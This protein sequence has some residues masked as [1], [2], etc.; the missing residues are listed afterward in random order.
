MALHRAIR[1]LRLDGRTSADL[2]PG[3]FLVER[4]GRELALILARYER[5]LADDGLLD[6][7][8]LLGGAGRA[9]AK[10]PL[11]SLWVLSPL[12]SRLSRLEA[13]LVRS[14]AAGRLV[15]VPGDPVV[16]LD[17]PRQ[18]WPAPGPAD[19]SG[20]GRLTWLFAP[21]Q[22]P[23]EKEARIEIFRALGPA[24]ECREIL[25][26]LYAEKVPFDQVEILTPPGS[27]HA[28]V[29]HLFAERTGLPVTF[30]DGIPVSFTSPGRLFFGL[31][32]WLAGDFSSDELGRLLE[33]GDLALPAGPSGT[34]LPARTACRLLR[35]AMIGW[36]RDRYLERLAA[37]REGQEA[38]LA[39]LATGE[40]EEDGEDTDGRRSGFKE[41]IAGIEAL[42]AAIG[43]ILDIV[44]RPDAAGAYDLRRLCEAFARLIGEYAGTASDLDGRARRALLDRL[45]EFAAESRLPDLPLK[46][47]LGLIRT[48]G[49]SLRVG[50]SPPLAGR[51]HVAALPSG[52]YSGRPYTFVAGLDEARV[53]GRGLQD[54]VLLDEER[55]AISPSLPTS[56]DAL[57]SG[58]YGLAAVLASLRGRI[59]LSYPSF[60]IVEG[61]ESFPS[62]VVLQAFRL[63]RGDPDLDY[64]ALDRALPE[65]AGF[66]PGGPARAFDEAD[67][68]LDRLTTEPRPDGRRSV[69]AN[70][71]AL[72]AGL[73]A[74][75]ARAG[76]RLTA[77]DGLVDIGPLRAEVDPV[78]GDR[79]V[80]SATRLE[81]LAKCPFGYFLRHVLKVQPPE[82][83]AF[84]RSR[85]LDPLQRGSLVHEILCEFMTAVAGRGEE[86]R[87]SRHAAVMTGIAE[88]HVARMKLRVPP[89]SDGIFESERREIRETLDIFM[90]AE[91]KREIKG[92]PLAFEKAIPGESIA[93]DGGR[94]FRLRGF[95]DRVDLDRPG[96]LP[97]HRLQDGQPRAVRGRR[98]FRPGPD[99]PARA[100]RRRP[101]TDAGPGTARPRAA[102][103][104]E[105]L[106][107]PVA[108]GRGRRDHGPG[109]RPGPAPVAARRPSRPPRKG[110]FHRRPR[111]QVRL[112]RLPGRLHLRR[113]RSLGREAR[114]Q[115]R[116]LRGL[117][118]AR[119]VQM[120]AA[121]KK[122]PPDQAARD[123]IRGDL[124]T[125]FLVEAGA[126]SGK[127][128]SL[129][130]RMVALLA[131]GRTS[132]ET[133]AAVT[134][135]RK[136]AAELRG[137][138]QVA[139]EQA[140]LAEKDPR[141]RERLDAALTGLERAFIGTIHSFC[142][143]LLRERPVEAGI[144]PEFR[145]LED[146]EDRILLER[147]WDEYQ[148]HARLENEA[149]LR[150][151]DEAG[152][153]PADLETAFRAIAGFPD[154]EPVAGRPDPPDHE[155][156]RGA[157]EKLV[158]LASKLVPREK[159]E[160]G[161]DG[162]QSLFVRLFRRRRNIGFADGRRLME[163]VELFDKNLAFMPTR[164][165]AKDDGK[166]LLAAAET[167]RDD[168]AR[169]AL[170]VWREFR[171][172]KALAFLRPAVGFYAERRRAEARLN[173]QDQLMLTAR[174]L[175]D[176]PEVRRY[177]RRRFHP[178]LVDE[179]Q[180][181][182]PI[183]A[184]ILFLL[185]GT[186]ETEKDWTR[187][188]PAPGSL[189][190]VG[191]PKQSIYRF[192][193]ADI[194]IYNLVRDRIEASGGETLALSANFRSLG[195]IAD[196]VNP[197]FDPGR[198]GVF[199]AAADA[200]QAGFMPLETVRGRGRGPLSGVRKITVPAVPY[201]R[202][203]DIAG[204]DA[205]RVAGFIAWALA[206]N[207]R[208]DDGAGGDRPAEPGD[209][210]V[211]F[212]YKDRMSRYARRLEERGIPFEIAGS[213]AFAEN[214]EIREVMN[215]LRA[216]DDPDDPVASVAVLRGMFFGLS[217]QDLLD[218]RAA[219]GG[220][221]FL[222]E[223]GGPA[224]SARI[225]S[226]FGALRAWRELATRVPPSVALETDHPGFGPAHPPGHD[227]DGQ[228]PGRQRPQA[229]RGPAR[230]RE[231]GHDLLRRGRGLPGRM[232]R[233][234]ARRGDEPRAGPPQRRAAHEPAQ[235]QRPR[236]PGR[237]AGQPGRGGRL[238]AGPA[239]PPDGPDTARPF[240]LHQA[241][242]PPDPDGL[243][244]RRL[245][246]E[247]GR[248]AEI[249]GSR[250][251]PADVRGGHPGPG[252]SRRQRLRRR[253]QGEKGLGPARAGIGGRSKTCPTV[254]PAR[255]RRAPRRLRGR[256]APSSPAK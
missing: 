219:G 163:S 234:H 254:R 14:A 87:T 134:F 135:T 82:E 162:L 20:A 189:F 210:L 183:Q 250:G 76:D 44:P 179:F 36:G 8:G 152:L 164:W 64:A 133:L 200:Y 132:I 69:A 29:L 91:E 137:R 186:S 127:T 204:F 232:G 77:H 28:T 4:K 79:A 206:G 190:L 138:F 27:G 131:T 54:P 142:A 139:L 67:W 239:R 238:R 240:P 108:A 197:L 39:A 187:L 17:R 159:P 256:R 100:L 144:D 56:A 117:R 141:T 60:D 37:L 151:L 184:E 252:P 13:E 226:A 221:C 106:S 105:R 63:L 80:M 150:G 52:G 215:L 81:L 233:S 207:L 1:E 99:A 156:V 205:V 160:K 253:P 245:G 247:R 248:G 85:W 15:L 181:T 196:W 66:L 229:H 113:P 126:G 225:R 203:E 216:L 2:K 218:H 116:G 23:P 90:A 88:A 178:I 45:G 211:L 84:D 16:G 146:H 103:R 110:L 180:D 192:R 115:S 251:E 244:T 185:T 57:R 26:R 158:D 96:H 209:F 129:V 193:R 35:N 166:R 25:R 51:L 208:L 227:R 161:R 140:R 214:A 223:A 50:A 19:L 94:S 169:P 198:G 145:E 109:F 71:P 249:R 21:R 153:A 213:D 24:N 243:P 59:V 58:L 176:N 175:R 86:V 9:A 230:P 195:A 95:I 122:A 217:D 255:D 32:A 7:A 112:L 154:V 201:H 62:S 224:G 48:A 168:V 72:D 5:A 68:W 124:G 10:G 40:G 120:M 78:N 202:K 130:D 46:E 31:T 246:G 182:D 34:A 114:G 119:R 11:A 97:D 191:D 73:A 167:F 148:A 235:G 199:P 155:A 212:R 236:G 70:F 42:S 102:R 47:A 101:R 174:L 111:G 121:R 55:A 18:A 170:R 173:F 172:T 30:G 177:F 188:A 107:L 222:A 65:A 61:R 43:R 6:L 38:D 75:E 123:R 74:L 53:P 33:N 128:K 49:V 93:L 231:R 241:G 89:P 136:A 143:R 125:T 171:H 22:A 220:F 237:L 118:Q 104:R 83:V 3:Q 149:A 242:R 157:L 194:D 147:S 12:D 41:A 98:P 92:R 228:Q 165:P